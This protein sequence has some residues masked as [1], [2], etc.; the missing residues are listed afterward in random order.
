M[1]CK[2][3]FF[4][5]LIFSINVFSF[6]EGFAKNKAIDIAYRDYGPKNATPI[7]LVTGLGAQLTLWPD[8]L[9]NDLQENNFRT[10]TASG[11]VLNSPLLMVDSNQ[12]HS[13]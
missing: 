3:L 10:T 6:E 11:V 4:L 2:N 9:I 7:L 1:H 5:I 12:I 8:F 13:Q